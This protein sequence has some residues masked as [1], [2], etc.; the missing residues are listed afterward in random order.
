MDEQLSLDQLWSRVLAEVQKRR[1]L[2][3][4]W[5]EPATPLSLDDSTLTL[6]FSEEKLLGHG[7]PIQARTPKISG[8]GSLSASWKPTGSELPEITTAR[9]ARTAAGGNF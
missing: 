5:L 6:G 1:P 8:R 9:T 7:V 3:Q 4:A 2:I